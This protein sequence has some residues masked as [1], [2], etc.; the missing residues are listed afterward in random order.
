MPYGNINAQLAPAD[1]QAIKDAFAAALA[2]LPF[3]V[4]LTPDE[5][6]A[7]TKT[8]PDSVSY[9]QDALS[10]VVAAPAVFPASVDAPGY[11]NDVNLFTVL[12]ELTTLAQS[13][14]STID[15]TR[16]AVGSEAMQTANAIYGYAKTAQKNTPG[17][18]PIVD[19]LGARYAKLTGPRK[20]TPAAKPA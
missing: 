9:V 20:Q 12:T 5:R 6:K 15:D 7:L 16:M 18:K 3:A 14:A 19:K 8:G 13:V 17:L 10:A 2:K 4:N 1:V 11:T